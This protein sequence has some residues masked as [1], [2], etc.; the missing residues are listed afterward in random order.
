[1]GADRYRGGLSGVA[2]RR[3]RWLLFLLPVVCLVLVA[4][5]AGLSTSSAAS[6]K[7]QRTVIILWHQEQVANRI[8]QWQSIID[9]FNKSQSKYEVKQQVQNWATIYQKLPPAI[10]AGKQPDIQFTIPDFTVNIKKTGVVQPVDSIVKQLDQLHHFLPAATK[11][12]TYD[13]HVWSVPLYGMVQILFYRKDQFKAAGLDPNKPPKTWSELLAD[14]KKLTR[15]GHYGIGVPLAKSL[16]TDQVIYSFMAT[17]HGKD[18]IDS[19][20]KITF[21][22]PANVKTFD[23]YA[24]LAKASPTGNTSWTWAEPMDAFDSG[25]TAMA[26]EKGMYLRTWLSVA[27]M[28]ASQLGCAP[29]PIAPGGQRGSIYYSNAAMVLTKDPAKVAGVTAFFKYVLQPKVYAKFLLAEPGLFLPLTGDGNTA[30]WSKSPQLAPF[31]ACLKM[32]MDQSKYGYLFGFTTDK[33]YPAIGPIGAQS[34]MAQAA[35]KIVLGHQT[36]AQAVAWGQQEM[37]RAAK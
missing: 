10:S 34:I 37:Q 2:G 15:N 26:V 23:F 16:A 18:L 28:P 8:N 35:Q 31:P 17:N 32:L 19:N 9:A 21:N 25:T 11:P 20:G 13:G 30:A 36:A 6:K 5:A 14:V 1:M 3:F 12:Y 24:K 22:T 33:V 4:L 7:S 27:K 29:V